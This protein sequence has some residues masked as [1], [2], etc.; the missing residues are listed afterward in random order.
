MADYLSQEQ[1]DLLP[2]GSLVIITWSGGNGPHEYVTKKYC[3]S[4]YV[5]SCVTGEINFGA[6]PVDFVGD[7]KPFTLVTLKE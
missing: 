5:L 7:K 1:V 3:D 6:G 2:D 4:V